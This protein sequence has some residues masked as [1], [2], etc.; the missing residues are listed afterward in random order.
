MYDKEF[1]LDVSRCKKQVKKGYHDKRLD[2]YRPNLNR[3]ALLALIARAGKLHVHKA[4]RTHEQ[5]GDEVEKEHGPEI[6]KQISQTPSRLRNEGRKSKFQEDRVA[7]KNMVSIA[8]VR[9]VS[10]DLRKKNS[11]GSSATVTATEMI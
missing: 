10:D 1:A 11:E 4:P 7:P 9:D 6:A 3:P 5:H 2:K 8:P